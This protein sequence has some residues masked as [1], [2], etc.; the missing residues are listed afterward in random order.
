MWQ[1]GIQAYLKG[2]NNIKDLQDE[3]K[4]KD[5]ISKKSGVIYR[6]KGK[7]VDCDEYI[8]ESSRTFGK[9]FKEHLKVPSPVHNHCSLTSHTT[10]VDNFNTD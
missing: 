5:P 2:G 10:V 1:H 3:P 6:Y 9:R 4:D 7:I 8:G